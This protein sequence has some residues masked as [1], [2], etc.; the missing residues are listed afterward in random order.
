MMESF[1]DHSF[2]WYLS[3]AIALLGTGVI[4][5]LLAGLLGVGGGIVIVPVLY[6]V[7]TLLG[8]D[9]TLKMHI[10]VGTSLATI[11]PTSIASSIAH[12]KK[13][14]IDKNLVSQLIPGV[15]VGVIVG[16]YSSGLISSGTLT[17]I[18]AVIALM[19][20]GNMI[21]GSK[22]FRISDRLPSRPGTTVIATCIGSLSALMGIGGGTLSVPILNA[23]KVPMHKAVGTGAALGILISIPGSAGFIYNGLGAENLPPL[24]IGYLNLIG[25]AL[26]TP[27]TMKMAPIGAEIGHKIDQNLLKK[28]FAVFLGLTSL[29]MFY[30]LI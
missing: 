3:L 23:F 6:H 12:Y 8:I 25:F 1:P 26:I 20:S 27:T 10:A 7:F 22:S 15:L 2:I 13:G 18:F 16:T 28:L 9:E 4:A 14:N 17:I 29:K 21:L 24:S 19:V 5:G 30:A 11:V